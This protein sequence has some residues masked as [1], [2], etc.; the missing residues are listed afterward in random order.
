M[1][2]DAAALCD[3]HNDDVADTSAL[4]V[5]HTVVLGEAEAGADVAMG[6][7]VEVAHALVDA[8]AD[9]GAAVSLREPLGEGLDDASTLPLPH[10]DGDAERDASSD[11]AAGVADVQSVELCEGAP[12]EVPL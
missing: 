11:D 6:E 8:A 10:T 7:S 2:S 3:A 4:A 5:V 1:S 12:D 9:D